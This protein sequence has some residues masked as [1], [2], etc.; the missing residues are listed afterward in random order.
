[1]SQPR[2][3]RSCFSR[4]ALAAGVALPALACSVTIPPPAPQRSSSELTNCAVAAAGDGEVWAALQTYEGPPPLS[5]HPSSAGYHLARIHPETRRVLATFPVDT[6]TLLITDLAV[7]HGGVWVA[8]QGF[9]SGVVQKLDPVTGQVAAKVN[10]DAGGFV[11]GRK[12]PLLGVGRSAVWAVVA[13]GKSLYRLDPQSGVVIGVTP[14]DE[15]TL[16]AEPLAFGF[17]SVWVLNNEGV[18]RLS[19]DGR[20]LAAIPL[21]WRAL[22]SRFKSA[23]AS[24]ATGPSGVWVS[25]RLFLLR[26]DPDTNRVSEHVFEAPTD[27]SKTRLAKILAFHAL[28]AVGEKTVWL[29][30][31]NLLSS[32]FVFEVDTQTNVIRKRIH[33]EAASEPMWEP[34]M[35][36]SW[37]C[38]GGQIRSLPPAGWKS[39]AMGGSNGE[40]RAEAPESPDRS[41]ARRRPGPR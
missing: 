34:N 23:H 30:G 17:G 10:L 19:E 25:T 3:T 20:V 41:R 29:S 9:S 33:E 21:D 32:E 12:S 40:E 35:E 2:R 13:G 37:W 8:S 4:A 7:G 27:P 1:M 31:G 16:A 39:G 28:R 5:P 38:E 6:G 18:L 24:L 11:V 14:L 26:I 15:R 22:K 36:T